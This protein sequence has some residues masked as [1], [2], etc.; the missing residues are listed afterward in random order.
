ML[1]VVLSKE[2]LKD[3]MRMNDVCNVMQIFQKAVNLDSRI[4]PSANKHKRGFSDVFRGYRNG[5]F[6]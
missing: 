3:Y 1:R 4:P 5:S 6:A 2:T